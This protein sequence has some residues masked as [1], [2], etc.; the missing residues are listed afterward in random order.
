M[1]K[2]TNCELFEGVEVFIFIDT[3]SWYNDDE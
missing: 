1:S 2:K 3:P